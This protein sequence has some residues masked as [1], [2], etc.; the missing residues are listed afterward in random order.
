MLLECTFIVLSLGTEFELQRMIGDV[1]LFMHDIEDR[2]NAEIEIMIAS[3]QHRRQGYGRDAVLLMMRYG[4]VNLNIRRFFAKINSNNKQ[5][6][7]LFVR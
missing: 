3:L 2:L 4:I 6:I 1:N 5:S 7:K